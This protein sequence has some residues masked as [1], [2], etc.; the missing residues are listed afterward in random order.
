MFPC[1]R[2]AAG[3]GGPLP[4]VACRH[5]PT[6]LYKCVYKHGL[7]P[8]QVFLTASATLREQVA[9][10]FRRL[11]A[12]APNAPPA[13]A[14]EAAAAELHT[15]ASVPGIAFPLFLSTKKYLHMLDGTLPNP[16]FPRCV[17]LLVCS[18]CVS[19][20]VFRTKCASTRWTARYLTRLLCNAWPLLGCSSFVSGVVPS[21]GFLATAGR[22]PAAPQFAPEMGNFKGDCMACGCSLSCHSSAAAIH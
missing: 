19:P 7:L 5:N 22:T 2:D 16:F 6:D 11:Q 9:M 20:A 1:Q 14:A 10:S 18:I 17:L 4:S 21:S 3:S 12:A 13:G 8:L 15:F